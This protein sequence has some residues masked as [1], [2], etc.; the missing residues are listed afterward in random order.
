MG[1][2]VE[3]G[4]KIR[5]RPGQIKRDQS[6]ALPELF[7]SV[8]GGLLGLG[9]GW[10]KLGGSAK[11]DASTSE[12]IVHYQYR[13]QTW[14]KCARG[15]VIRLDWAGWRECQTPSEISWDRKV[16]KA[17]NALSWATGENERNW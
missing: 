11:A 3:V 9:S 6:A 16:H 1:R 14:D 5:K 4:G 15:H 7:V 12:K 13:N 17:E 2:T 8:Q 10:E